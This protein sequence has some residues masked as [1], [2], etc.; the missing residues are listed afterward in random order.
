MLASMIS[1]TQKLVTE[2]KERMEEYYEADEILDTF[3]FPDDYD[4]SVT[5]PTNAKVSLTNSGESSLISSDA[6][7]NVSVYSNNTFGKS[8][9]AYKLR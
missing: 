2:S 8:V 9:Y 3:S 4:G 5:G 7:I 6:P 1:T